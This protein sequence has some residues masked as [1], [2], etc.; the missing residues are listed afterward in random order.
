MAAGRAMKRCRLLGAMGGGGWGWLWS[1]SKEK[2]VVTTGEWVMEGGGG[3]RVFP[4]PTRRRRGNASPGLRHC[5]TAT[6]WYFVLDASSPPPAPPT[7][8]VAPGAEKTMAGLVGY[9]S[10][11]EEEDGQ[12]QSPVPSPGQDAPVRPGAGPRQTP[13]PGARVAHCSLSQAA[14]PVAGAAS[15]GAGGCPTRRTPRSTRVACADARSPSAAEQPLPPPGAEPAAAVAPVSQSAVPLGPSLPPPADASAAADD[16]Y[17]ADAPSSPYSANR[18]LIHHLTLPSIP[19]FDIPPRPRAS[20]R[21]GVRAGASTSF[22]RSRRGARTSTPSSSS[23][24]RCGTRP[25]RTSSST[26]SA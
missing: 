1:R 11:D 12:G 6:S 22:W 19:N 4:A 24:R 18:A 14:H 10:S 17:Q 8:A 2:H 23:R 25:S 26:L 9:G 20:R 5:S 7:P 3:S 21:R 13:P 15:A 16:W